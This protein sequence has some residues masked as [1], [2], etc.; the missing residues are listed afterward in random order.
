MAGR[1][2]PG[3]PLTSPPNIA[4]PSIA[5]F[6][7]PSANRQHSSHPPMVH[8]R[9]VV[10]HVRHLSEEGELPLFVWTLGLPQRVLYH[11]LDTCNLPTDPLGTMES[12]EF[13]Q[14]KQLVP[15]AYHDLRRMLFQHRTRLIDTTHADYLSRTVA[16]ACFGSQQLW[17]D[18]GVASE[19]EFASFMATFFTPLSVRHKHC[20][21]WKQQLFTEL[22]TLQHRATSSVSIPDLLLKCLLMRQ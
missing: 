13:E 14:I 7:A 17:E 2:E 3:T 1:P 19:G 11:L 6:S 12:A 20:R 16:A 5:T 21:H 8:L 4:M 18:L 9:D 15:D 22:H 10:A